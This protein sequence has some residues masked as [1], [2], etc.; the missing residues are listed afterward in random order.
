[1]AGEAEEEAHMDEAHVEQILP[2]PLPPRRMR[3][4]RRLQRSRTTVTRRVHHRG[5][6]AAAAADQLQ[7]SSILI[8]FK[9]IFV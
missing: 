5:R 4:A 6:L 2:P 8:L 7:V 3:H 1:M 9:F